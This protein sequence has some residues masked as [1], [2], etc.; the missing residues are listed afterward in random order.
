MTNTNCKTVELTPEVHMKLESAKEKIKNEDSI[1]ISELKVIEL[2]L[3]TLNAHLDSGKG[4]SNVP[5]FTL[6]TVKTG[7]VSVQKNSKGF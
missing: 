6:A 4:I 5:P 7:Q 3:H 2:A 1:N